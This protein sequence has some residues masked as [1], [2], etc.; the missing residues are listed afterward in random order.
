M[1]RQP[2]L[3]RHETVTGRLI[4]LPQLILA[5]RNI[6]LVKQ[7]SALKHHVAELYAFLGSET[8]KVVVVERLNFIIRNVNLVAEVVG[9]DIYHADLPRL[10]AQADQSVDFRLGDRK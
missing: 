10:I 8:V 3:R 4:M 1:G 2:A 5:Q 7:I 6:V 9:T